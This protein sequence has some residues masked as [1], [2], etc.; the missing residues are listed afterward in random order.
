MHVIICSLDVRT[1]VTE[2][3][4]GRS[5]CVEVAAHESG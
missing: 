1:S 2:L 5:Q 3:M 4:R